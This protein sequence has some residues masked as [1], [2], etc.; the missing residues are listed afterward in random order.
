M[1]MANTMLFITPPLLRL[2][3]AAEFLYR[4]TDAGFIHLGPFRIAFQP[5][6]PPMS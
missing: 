5:R 1:A 2:P 3:E 4:T 6:A